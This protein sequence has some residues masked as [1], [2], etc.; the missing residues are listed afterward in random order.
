MMY[1][2]EPFLGIYGVGGLVKATTPNRESYPGN[3]NAILCNWSSQTEFAQQ[4]EIRPA[5]TGI[6][7]KQ[8]GIHVP[9]RPHPPPPLTRNRHP[10]PQLGIRP[11]SR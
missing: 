11:G 9:P 5:Q 4:L 3:Q 7:A 6:E 8:L 10:P 2:S 1:V